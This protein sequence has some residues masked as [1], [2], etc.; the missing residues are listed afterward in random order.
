MPFPRQVLPLILTPF[1]LIGCQQAGSPGAVVG[2]PGPILGAPGGNS[3]SAASVTEL[4][5][6]I[7]TANKT[8]SVATTISLTEGKTYT[9]YGVDNVKLGPTG[10]PIVSGNVTID[11]NGAVLLRSDE[12]KVPSFRFFAVNPGGRLTLDHLTLKNG[13]VDVIGGGSTGGA[14]FNSGGTLVISGSTLIANAAG[15]GG[16][17]AT[18]LD[19]TASGSTQITGST[20]SGNTATDTGTGGG[21]VYNDGGNLLISGSTL[22]GNTADLGGAVYSDTQGI[23]ADAGSLTRVVNSTLSGNTATGRGGGGVYNESGRTEILHSTI[24]ANTAGYRGGGVLS[25]DDSTSVLTRL[26]GSIIAGNTGGSDVELRFSSSDS[27]YQSGGS[28]VVGKVGKYVV[29]GTTD[30][31]AVTDP[32][33][34][35]LADNGGSTFTHALTR[36]SV[37]TDTSP[38]SGCGPD[39][40][41][42]GSSRPEGISCDSG[43]YEFGATPSGLQP[44]TTAPGRDDLDWAQTVPLGS[45]WVAG[46]QVR[47]ATSFV[48]ASG[49]ESAQGPWTPWIGASPFALPMLTDIP[50]DP[51]NKAVARNVYRQF[52]ADYDSNHPK[53][54]VTQII[55]LNDNTTTSA[56]DEN[57]P[58]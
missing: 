39:T 23:S 33:L 29:F 45:R 4:V 55:T 18:E 26:E 17:I 32:G 9:L 12:Q 53:A 16:A 38:E 15:A 37:A 28:N 13:D 3:V 1:L 49:D 5:T 44:P 7:N 22:T 20:L 40:D 46:Y 30:Q 34:L 35:P 48:D 11:G 51:A 19:S 58:R 2:S 27:S 41:Q 8:P 52:M 47:Y 21:A 50:T 31:T 14:V 57:V 56:R 54:G 10:L 42:R 43:A 6:A 24:T 36:Q 25:F